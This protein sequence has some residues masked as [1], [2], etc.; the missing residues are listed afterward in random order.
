[1]RTHTIAI[2]SFLRRRFDDRLSC[3]GNYTIQ[4][5]ITA[6]FHTFLSLHERIPK[7]SIP[8]WAGETRYRRVRYAVSWVYPRVGGGNSNNRRLCRFVIGL[9]PRGRGKLSGVDTAGNTR[10]S[11]PAWAGETH[12]HIKPPSAKKVYPR[13][14]G[15]NVGAGIIISDL[16]GLSPRG[17]GKPLAGVQK[18]S[19]QRSIPAWA[20]ETEC[21]IRCRRYAEVYPRVGGGNTDNL[22][23]VANAGGLSPRGRGKP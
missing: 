14:G 20:G 9:S 21:Q 3:T 4:Y 16:L 22:L 15:G 5:A 2:D 13:V 19:A 18:D 23:A 17:R 7:R 10:R 6:R 11:I 8:A 12:Y 1:M